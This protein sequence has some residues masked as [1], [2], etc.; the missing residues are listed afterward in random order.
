[1]VSAP[2]LRLSLL[3]LAPKTG[4]FAGNARN[5]QLAMRV[6]AARGAALAITPELALPGFL[7]RANGVASIEAQPDRWLRTIAATARHLGIAVLVGTAERDRVTGNLHNSAFLIDPTGAVSGHCRKINVAADGW[8][9]PGDTVMPMEWQTLRIGGLICADAYTPD[10]AARLSAGGADILISPANWGPGVHGPAGEWE[11]R[12]R[13]TGLPF[14]VCNRTGR[15][16]G[17]DFSAAESVVIVE[18]ERLMVHRSAHPVT[19]TLNWDT[20][21]G[22]PGSPDFVTDIL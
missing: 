12:S 9:R 1:M 17:L 8:S 18:G 7:F 3:H 2:C 15:E 10:I 5:I 13:E 16:S 14:I 21:A 11:E 22:L 6:A 19:L 4:D 20:V